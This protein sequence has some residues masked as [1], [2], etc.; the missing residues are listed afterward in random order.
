MAHRARRA[1]ARNDAIRPEGRTVHRLTGDG[2]PAEGERRTGPEPDRPAPGGDPPAAGGAALRKAS[3]GRNRSRPSSPR[4]SFRFR[5]TR[6]SSPRSFPAPTC[7]SSDRRGP[8]RPA[9]RRTCGAS[10]PRGSGRSVIARVLDHPMSV[11]DPATF[12]R[13]PP[14]PICR[15]RFS[16]D[17]NVGNFSPSTVD[18]TKVPA[19][20]VRLREGYGFARLQGS[21]EVFPDH[22]TG[23]INLRKLE[24]IGDPMSPLAL[25]P[26][27]ATSGESGPA[28]RR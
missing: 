16:P 10:S 23:N 25:E 22:L 21:S 3:I 9:S 18:P 6:M 28:P 20:F 11:I 2:R 17:Q 15:R 4:P 8:A 27:K 19:E 14:C 26:G 7:S 24:E 5:P 1:R 12:A 13:L